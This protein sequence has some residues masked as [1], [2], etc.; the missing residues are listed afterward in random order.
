MKFLTKKDYK[1]PQ[2]E[3]MYV[4]CEKGFLGSTEDLTFDDGED[5]GWSK[6]Y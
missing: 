4:I 3:V 6:L 1:T 5:G 2:V